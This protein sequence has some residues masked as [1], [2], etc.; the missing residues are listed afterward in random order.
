MESGAIKRKGFRVN[1]SG[2][3]PAY[4]LAAHHAAFSTSAFCKVQLILRRLRGEWLGWRIYGWA[5][6]I[7]TQF[8]QQIFSAAPF[9][10]IRFGLHAGT[11]FANA[12]GERLSAGADYQVLGICGV[13]NGLMDVK[14][15]LSNSRYKKWSWWL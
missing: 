6:P 5:Y 15:L 10:R 11:L 14:S 2:A 12:N 3:N 13:D 4:H 1:T 9:C 8:F 7:F